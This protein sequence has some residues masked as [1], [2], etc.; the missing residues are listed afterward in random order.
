MNTKVPDL[1]VFNADR[2][3]CYGAVKNAIEMSED[4]RFNTC[5]ELSFK[6]TEKFC[7]PVTG[8]FIDNPIYNHLE[9]YN[10]IYS[11]DDTNYFRFPNRTI[12]TDYAIKNISDFDLSYGRSTLEDAPTTYENLKNVNNDGVLTGFS[13]QPETDLHHI[14]VVGGYS[15]WN[16]SDIT[17]F[18]FNRQPQTLG[19]YYMVACDEYVPIDIYD[20]IAL[21]TT[22]G[23][24]KY[25]SNIRFY[26][27][28]IWFY[29]NNDSNDCLGWLDVYSGYTPDGRSV[30]N[31]RTEAYPVF[32]FNIAS[33]YSTNADLHLLNSITDDEF[34]RKMK[35]N[36]M[37]RVSV[38][39]GHRDDVSASIA[40]KRE[41][42]SFKYKQNDEDYIGW[43]FPYDGWCVIYSGNRFCSQIDN[44]ISDGY[45]DMPL[46]WFVIT[47]TE[48]ESDGNN[49]FKTVTAYSY[50]YTM[51]YKT[52]SLSEDT[53]SLY[54]PPQITNIVENSNWVIDKEK[55]S[56]YYKKGKQHLC[57]GLLNQVLE[58]IPDWS[59]GH[60]SSSLMTRYRKISDVDNINVYSFLMNDIES[61][62]QCYFVFDCDNKTISA[63]TQ[64]DLVENNCN[65]LLN[66]NNALKD[67][68]IENTDT[69]I[70]TSLRV[71]SADDTYGLGLV[72]PTGNNN[73]Y[74]F[75]S[76]LDEMDY[77]ADDSDDDPLQRNKI[78][79][80]G[81]TRNRTLKEAVIAFM[82][83][84]ESPSSYDGNGITVQLTTKVGD[85]D[86]SQ[87]TYTSQTI[88]INNLSDYRNVSEK[89]ILKNL[90]RIKCKT[91]LD[92]CYSTYLSVLNKIEVRV[93]YLNE[94]LSEENKIVPYKEEV[95]RT[96]TSG[97]DS[98]RNYYYSVFSNQRKFASLQLFQELL[99]AAVDYHKARCEYE[100]QD[101]DYKAYYSVLRQIASRANLNYPNQVKLTNSYRNHR[102]YDEDGNRLILSIL[103]PNEIM[104]LI[105][106]IREGD[107]TNDNSVFSD[108][109]DAKDIITTLVDVYN[110]A[111]CDMD[112]FISKPQYDFSTSVVNWTVIP[113]MEKSFNNLKVGQTIYINTEKDY[114]VIP[115]LL[116]LHIN[117]LDKE[118]F[119]MSFTTNYK[120]KVTELRFYDLYSA[121]NS[122]DVSDSTFKFNE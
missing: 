22:S 106:Y 13:L 54:I 103:T 75:Q 58:V 41:Y 19:R 15:W 82:N 40:M 62:Y 112:T 46:H 70:T 84:C 53:L 35:N 59:I 18:G 68:K 52:I 17:E 38:E 93:D 66:W 78:T 5:S 92:E 57:G 104:A 119:S 89:F 48:E 90:D 100:A 116:E 37:I 50:E 26:K 36:G 55:N 99:N 113:E 107:W 12:R 118:D 25:Q 73:I 23:S 94:S 86:E 95:V 105:P 71:H 56:T 44:D 81:V 63:Y 72:S 117:Y 42:S 14:G 39:D 27:Y 16:L 29:T 24:G 83:F 88:Y 114:Y 115:M 91:S 3:K 28:T 122:I 85:G 98:L 33:L 9:K 31:H 61:L 69:S 64:D 43:S 1:Y 79:E 101:N 110:Q 4:V 97:Y 49:K 111:K 2:K 120:R 80:G 121:V 8:E 32:R 96:P 11:C 65:V 30:E 47:D 108:D 34:K 20:V 102:Y 109:Y 87:N 67:L 10:L 21:K 51:S 74:N 6:V 7:D 77:V 76:V 45:Y 60:V